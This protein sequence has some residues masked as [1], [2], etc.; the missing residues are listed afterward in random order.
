MINKPERIAII[1]MSILFI[2]T[3]LPIKNYGMLACSLAD[4]NSEYKE[5][6]R[7][8]EMILYATFSLKKKWPHSMYPTQLPEASAETSGGLWR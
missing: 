7:C 6:Y 1:P 5:R 8:V 4:V 2:I 3:T